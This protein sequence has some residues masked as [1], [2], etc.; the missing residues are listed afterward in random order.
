M[1]PILFHIGSYGVHSY[2][3]LL[4]LAIVFSVWRAYS[5]ARS[6]KAAAPA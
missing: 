6:R 4:M 1:R 3:V 2:G 5:H